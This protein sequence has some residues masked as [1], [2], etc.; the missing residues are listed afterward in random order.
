MTK[1]LWGVIAVFSLLEWTVIPA[2]AQKRDSERQVTALEEVVVYARRRQ[3][4]LQQTPIAVTAFSGDQLAQAGVNSILDLNRIVPSLSI[5]EDGSKEPKFFIRGIGARSGG[6]FLDPGVGIYLNEILIPRPIGQL[7]ETVDIESVQALRGPQG[8]LFGKN[9][10][11]GA[12]LFRTAQPDLSETSAK[13]TARVGDHRRRD[14]RVLA[15]MP[16]LDDRLA[17]RL[18]LSR[19]YT[20]G[21]LDNVVD[22]ETLGGVV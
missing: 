8:T 3:E 4:L 1:K 19:T 20:E 17:A 10:T 7:L 15:N 13:V 22:G 14:F 11:G 5:S 2:M 21:F 18:A 6:T 9:N 12:I 16:I